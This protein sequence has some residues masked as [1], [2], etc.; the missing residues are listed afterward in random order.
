MQLYE[1]NINSTV[2]KI[3]TSK[4]QTEASLLDLNHSMRVVLDIDLKTR[5]ITAATA[6]ILK[7]PLR[8]CDGTVDLVK[9]L[10]GLKLERGINRKLVEALGGDDGCTH[11]YELALNAVRLSFN[12]MVGMSYN[13]QEWVS[14]TKSDQEFVKSAMP[15]LK[16]SCRP[17]KS[18]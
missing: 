7:A 5:E 6:T 4:I 12:V 11:L 9:K 2:R 10:K 16:N 18:R 1:R 17:F 13:W 3:G 8:A 14:K 15:Y